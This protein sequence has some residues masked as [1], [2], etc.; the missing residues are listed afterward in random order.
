MIVKTF[1]DRVNVYIMT[2]MRNSRLDMLEMLV[3]GAG[4][5]TYEWVTGPTIS[6]LQMPNNEWVHSLQ[7]PLASHPTLGR[8]ITSSRNY[9][10]NRVVPQTL[11]EMENAIRTYAGQQ[12][13]REW[14]ANVDHD[15]IRIVGDFEEGFEKTIGPEALKVVERRLEQC[16]S[17]TR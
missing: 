13:R 7:L 3:D 9:L 6:T 17:R 11:Q 1:D 4:P 12:S 15:M 16:M 8:I 5:L 14:D 10:V 2:S